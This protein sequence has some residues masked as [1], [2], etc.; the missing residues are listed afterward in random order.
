MRLVRHCDQ[1]ERET[2]GAVHWNSP[3]PKLQGA[4]EKSGERRFSDTDWLQ[5]IYQGSN[6]MR[7][8]YCRNSISSL[9]YI[10]VIRGH[11]GG[12]LKAPELMGHVAI[13]YKWKEFLFHRGCSFNVTSILTSGLIA[14][15]R[16]SKEGRQIIF[17]TPPNPFG[18]NPDEEE[19]C[20]DLSKPK[21]VHYHS[22]WKTTQD[23]VCWINSARAQDKGLRFRQTR[24]HAVIVYNSV[25]ADCIY[26]VT[27]QKGTNFVRETFDASSRT[28]DCTQECLAIAA[29]AATRH[30]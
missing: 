14:G 2:D 12:N 8:Q 23:A 16:E 28:E 27:S 13:P 21:K 9:L 15:G 4:F 26:K 1:D 10:C 18:D 3:V 7:F 11:T 29:A 20:D 6:K 24:S 19:L 30:L 5:H 17:F 25:P 22:K